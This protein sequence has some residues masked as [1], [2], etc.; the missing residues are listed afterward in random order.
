MALQTDS[1]RIPLL[2][3]DNTSE[4]HVLELQLQEL[5]KIAWTTEE[6]FRQLHFL[7]IYVC[8]FVASVKSLWLDINGHHHNKSIVQG[9]V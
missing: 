2:I 4:F 6:S 5:T 8:L 9:I 1:S 7:Q 3:G